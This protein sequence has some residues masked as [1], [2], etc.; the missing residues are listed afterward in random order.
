MTTQQQADAWDFE[1]FAARAYE[2]RQG[3]MTY[4][5]IARE[6]GYAS[7]SSARTAVN[8]HAA[9]IG[10]PH[11]YVQPSRVGQSRKN[12]TFG[13]EMEFV[14]ASKWAVAKAIERATGQEHVCIVGYHQKV[15]VCCGRRA[16][17][18][19]WRVEHDGSV[20]SG[21]A[22]DPHAY[23][24][25]IVTPV[26]R[27]Q[28]GLDKIKAVLDEVNRSTEATVDKTCGLHVHV[29]VSDITNEGRASI[30]RTWGNLGASI[31]RLVAKSRRYGSPEGNRFCARLEPHEADD[32]AD[33]IYHGRMPRYP[34]R[35]KSLN[36]T[37]YVK[38]G[39]FEVRQHQGTL[40]PRKISDWVKMLI[41]LFEAVGNSESVP[42]FGPGLAFLDHLVS[43]Q[44]LPAEVAESHKQRALALA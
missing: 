1:G 39:T 36:V 32:I 16:Y 35:Y 41:A 31:D 40:N 15:C 44:R 18:R 24:G 43:A 34:D 5:Q 22:R 6:V 26:L 20:S 12:R 10:A 27:G 37:S 29:G 19:D 8:R 25:E 17:K 30:V 4:A 9:R 28:A 23:G 2:L 42:M 13:V 7:E 33:R 38:Y 11:A 21:S 3:G 14:G